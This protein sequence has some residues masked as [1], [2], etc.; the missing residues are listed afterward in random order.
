[1]D[2]QTLEEALRT[3]SRATKQ[4]VSRETALREHFGDEEFAYLRK[5]ADRAARY[6]AHPKLGTVIVVNGIMGADLTVDDGDDQDLVWLSYGRL[7]L[8]RVGD[9]KL[10]PDG[11]KEADP[12]LAVTASGLNEDAYARLVLW[13]RA[14]WQVE[15]F[16]FDWRK[17]IDAASHALAAMIRTK[18]PDKP[19]HLVAHSMGGL[20]CR[21]FVR[22]H[23]AVWNAMRDASGNG[24]RLIM[25]G[26]P[27][28]GSFAIPQAITGEDPLVR[29]LAAVDLT[30]DR[31]EILEILNT[32]VGSYQMLPSPSKL[33]GP[34]QALYQRATW[35]RFPVSEPHLKRALAFHQDLDAPG[36]IDP[37]RMAYIAGANQETLTDLKILGPG[38]F[39]YVTT[40]D[41]DGRVPHAL[42]LLKGVPA[43]Y[44]EESHGDLPGNEDVL[45][46]V[47]DLLQRGST[48]QLPDQ[49][50]VR[51]AVSRAYSR[52]RAQIEDETVA[53]QLRTIARQANQHNATPAEIRFA[54]RTIIQTVM[55]MDRG[56]RT[57]RK[58]DGAP[59][60]MPPDET[61]PL[62]LRIVLGDITRVQAPTV[63]V[64]HYKGMLPVENRAE[65][66]LDRALRGWISKATL[67]GMVG[68]D[69][70]EL[71]FIPAPKEIGRAHV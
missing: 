7:I 11:G 35:D 28:Y 33:T 63:V 49:P 10:A 67:H 57:L 27:N 22:L 36:A 55:G 38:Q 41:G 29:L 2:W 32:F 52:W 60:R 65:G 58:P 53:R 70:G 59:A 44:V 68:S 31:N 50:P 34:L 39:D 54:E 40:Y 1:M 66:Q 24:G 8:G 20:V 17:D 61:I 13:L 18:F 6:R 14:Q 51:R 37:D 47:E 30:H 5:L 64:G 21:N 56:K 45:K 26:T 15:P 71:F 25:L 23:P 3:P 62:T 69:L 12:A 43:Y 16:P 46:A 4:D 42:G 48:S 9:L 19:V